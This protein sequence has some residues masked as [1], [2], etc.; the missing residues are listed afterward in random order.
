M[1]LGHCSPRSGAGP[2]VFQ[3][4]HP[5][6]SSSPSPYSPKDQSENNYTILEIH[7]GKRFPSFI[8]YS[9]PGLTEATFFLLHF[10]LFFFFP[11]LGSCC[12]AESL[13]QKDLSSLL[14]ASEHLHHQHPSLLP[15][16]GHG[17]VPAGLEVASTILPFH[18]P[19]QIK[20]G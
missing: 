7:Q 20:R 8:S 9:K 13:P 11:F 1:S 18:G 16:H 10:P 17:S 3:V 6:S 12:F 15:P 2:G 19:F 14:H 5:L 4:Q